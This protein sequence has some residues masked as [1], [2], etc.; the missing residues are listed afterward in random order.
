MTLTPEQKEHVT[1]LIE[2]GDKL[3]AVRYLKET[4]SI[5]L[6]QALVLAEK[7]E[8]ELESPAPPTLGE[9]GQPVKS[10]PGINVGKVVGSIFMTVGAI[11]LGIAAYVVSSHYKFEQRAQKVKGTVIDYHSYESKNDDGSYTTMYTPT[12]EY[13]FNGK[14]YKYTSNTSSSSQEYQINDAVQIL[15]DPLDPQNPLIDN[16]WEKWFLP[17]LLGFMGTLF[18]GLGFMGYWVLGREN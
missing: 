7:I 3:K 2:F 17:V 8:A 13:S 16:F 12:Y 9:D 10:S 4:L 15:V 1:E 14:S 18:G 5:S 6:D 11:M